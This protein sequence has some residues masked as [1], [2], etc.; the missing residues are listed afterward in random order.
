MKLG[1]IQPLRHRLVDHPSFDDPTPQRLGIDSTT[2]VA[3]LDQQHPT[4]VSRFEH[5]RRRLVLARRSSHVGDLD[6]MIDGVPQH[7]GE[8]R[9]ERGEDLAIDA[10][11]PTADF[12]PDL[13][14]EG[15]REVPDHAGKS[16]PTVFEGSHPT[17]E[18]LAVEIGGD[19]LGPAEQ[20]VELLDEF[21]NRTASLVDVSS[22]FRQWITGVAKRRPHPVLH[23]F[24]T[25]VQ[26]H[27]LLANAE[28]TP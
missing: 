13:L 7:M 21:R 3:H 25:T 5:Q 23:R 28:K 16:V 14:A 22:E 4:L 11:P 27:H 20:A 17:A 19:L 10:G 18:D 8:R 24:E 12:E 15:P 2:V 9:L 6:S 26:S 1:S